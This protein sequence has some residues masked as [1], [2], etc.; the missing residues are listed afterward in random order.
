M[1]R[2]ARLPKLRDV[3]TAVD[4]VDVDSLKWADCAI[5]AAFP[6]S[7][8]YRWESTRVQ[9]LEREITRHA[10]RVY[11]ISRDEKQLLQQAVGFENARVASNGVDLG[12]FTTDFVQESCRLS[13]C[14]VGVLDYLPNVEAVVWFANEVW[15]LIRERHPTAEFKVIGRSPSQAILRLASAPGVSICPDVPDVRPYLREST[16]AVAPLRIARGIQN[17]VLEAMAM[18]KPVVASPEALTGIE[19]EPGCDLLV[20]SHA[21]EWVQQ[22]DYL[23]TNPESMQTLSRRARRFVESNHDWSTCLLPFEELTESSDVVLKDSSPKTRHP[24]SASS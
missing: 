16:V 20:A 12:Y 2:Y 6:R 4:L 8:L 13:C 14:F 11:I 1:Y 5:G 19:A 17:K 7:W 23:F 22:V 15:G 10:D 18:G 3:P 9:K 21:S 24:L